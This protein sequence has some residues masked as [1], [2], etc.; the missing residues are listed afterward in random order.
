MNT[1][2]LYLSHFFL[3]L[4]SRELKVGLNHTTAYSSKWR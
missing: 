1:L 3:L 2:A 4:R